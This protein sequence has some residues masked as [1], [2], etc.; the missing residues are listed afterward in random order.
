MFNITIWLIEIFDQLIFWEKPLRVVKNKNQQ[1]IAFL[2]PHEV[3]SNAA[4]WKT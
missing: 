4:F 1:I 2:C 3:K